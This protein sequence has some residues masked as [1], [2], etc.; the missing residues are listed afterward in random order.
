MTFVSLSVL[1]GSAV[2]L[3]A[4]P[5]LHDEDNMLS[6][7]DGIDDAVIALSHSI[8][9]GGAG[10]LLAARRARS[11]TQRLNAGDETP[12]VPLLS[13]RLEFLRG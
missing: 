6:I 8:S 4:V 13:N 12:A 5:D 3:A 10:Q 9:I 1:L 11:G 7:V 2:D